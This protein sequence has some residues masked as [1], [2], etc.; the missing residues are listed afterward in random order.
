MHAILRTEPELAELLAYRIAL[1]GPVGGKERAGQDS[2]AVLTS[3]YLFHPLKFCC[4]QWEPGIRANG[5]VALCALGSGA[6]LSKGYRLV[7]GKVG[8]ACG[9]SPIEFSVRSGHGLP[10]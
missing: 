9:P 3:E 4:R 8:N 10:G 5:I 7:A 6:L 1:I 2:M